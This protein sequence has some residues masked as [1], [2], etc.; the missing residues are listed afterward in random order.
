[1]YTHEIVKI[2][3]PAHTTARQ[4]LLSSRSSRLSL[5]VSTPDAQAGNILLVCANQQDVSEFW[6]GITP[7]Q[8]SF[9]YRDYGP[10]IS[11]EI[12]IAVSDVANQVVI[13]GAEIYKVPS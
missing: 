3:I 1:M 12:W 9:P 4:K 6:Q 11:G 13:T 5:I 2:T 7:M 8:A 10:L